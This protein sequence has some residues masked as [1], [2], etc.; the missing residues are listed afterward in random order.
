MFRSDR[1]QSKRAHAIPGIAWSGC[2]AFG[3]AL[4]LVFVPPKPAAAQAVPGTCP[5]ALGTADLIDHDF[6]V[7]FCELCTTGTVRIAIDNPFDANDDVDLGD[8]VVSEDLLASGL[9]YVP[10]STT[11]SGAN[12]TVPPNVQPTVSGANSQILTWDLAG[13]GLV[14]PGRNGGAGNKARLFLEFDVERTNALGDEGLVAANR[15]IDAD[16][17]VEPSCA[18]VETYT[19]ST[20]PGLLPLREPEPVVIKT[21]RNVDAAQGSGSYSD[22]VYGHEGDDVI[23]RIQVRNDGDAP[24]QDFVF[25]DTIAPGNFAFSHVC[26][27]EAGATAGLR[28]PRLRHDGRQPRRPRDLRRG[29]ESVHRGPRQRQR[30]LLFR[31]QSDGFLLEPDQ[32]GLGCRLGLSVRAPGRRHHGDLGRCVD[33]RYGAPLDGLG[34]GQ[35]PDRRRADGRRDEPVDG[36][37]R[38]GDADDPQSVGGDDPRR[39]RGPA[40]QPD[41]AR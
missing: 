40:N 5:A 27:T 32:H 29:G 3:L 12:I 1:S 14:L 21:G 24:L 19:T 16:L 20:G 28:L 33:E 8:V 35:C 18:P 37:H 10:N 23:W 7:S 9:T 38:D 41:P 2:L 15:T 36:C 26:D 22:P 17:T 4:A 6:T 39:G 31:R 13:T 11:F 34:R 30:L 25:T